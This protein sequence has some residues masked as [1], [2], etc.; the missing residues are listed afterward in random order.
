MPSFMTLWSIGVSPKF[1]RLPPRLRACLLVVVD[2]PPGCSRETINLE[3][4]VNVFTTSRCRARDGEHIVE[5]ASRTREDLSLSL[6][7][8]AREVAKLAGDGRFISEDRH[9]SEFSRLYC[10]LPGAAG[11]SLEH[12]S[13]VQNVKYHLRARLFSK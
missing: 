7:V 12:V 6:S 4:R 9:N 1:P 11:S 3:S 5:Y 13:R 8:C 2:L 10:R